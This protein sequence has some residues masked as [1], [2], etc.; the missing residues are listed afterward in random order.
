VAG[1]AATF[2]TPDPQLIASDESVRASR[3]KS[4]SRPG[5]TLF[6]SHPRPA[7]RCMASDNVHH[8]RG[9]PRL[10]LRSRSSAR[11]DKM[12]A[13]SAKPSAI[14]FIIFDPFTSES[15]KRP[16]LPPAP[17]R[18]PSVRRRGG[19]GRDRVH[20][21]AASGKATS[22]ARIKLTDG[23][24]SPQKQGWRSAVRRTKWT[25]RCRGK[26]GTPPGAAGERPREPAQRGVPLGP[27]RARKPNRPIGAG[28]ASGPRKE[29]NRYTRH[30]LGT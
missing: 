5:W 7:A 18:L 8:A 17:A 13:W 2:I 10:H 11:N 27:V 20:S 29:G 12:T 3:R 22:Q 23:A 21:A 1:H 25:R 16:F 4:R 24:T 30:C 14:G 19:P 9:S 28:Q 6:A 26:R 15:W